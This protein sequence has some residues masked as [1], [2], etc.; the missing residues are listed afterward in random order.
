MLYCLEQDILW[1]NC[2]KIDKKKLKSVFNLVDI[3]SD[4]ELKRL[5]K[6]KL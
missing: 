6:R 1:V 5:E 4:A 2:Q 3:M